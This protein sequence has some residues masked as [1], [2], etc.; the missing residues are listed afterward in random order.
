VENVKHSSTVGGM[1]GLQA[2]ITALEI[3]LKVPQK[4]GYST[5]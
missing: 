4:I 3:S 1:V 5:T 2:D